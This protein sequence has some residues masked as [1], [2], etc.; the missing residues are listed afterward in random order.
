MFLLKSSKINPELV[1][2]TCEVLKLVEP[3]TVRKYKHYTNTGVVFT[4]PTKLAFKHLPETKIKTQ[5]TLW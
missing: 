4:Q 2:M 3:L 1:E 5:Y